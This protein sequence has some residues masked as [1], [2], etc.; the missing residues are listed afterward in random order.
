MNEMI[1]FRAVQGLGAGGLVIGAQAII[2][3]I[4]SPRERARYQGL[5]GAIF[6]LA[7]VVGPLVGGFFVDNLT[8]RWIFYINLPVGAVA[9]VIIG[10]VLTLP[11]PQ[12]RPRADFAG[13]A[14]LG[15]STVCIVLMFSWGGT[16][17]PWL[18]PQVIAVTAGAVIL[19]AAWAASASRAADPVLPLRLFRD[20][21]FVIACAISLILGIALFGAIAYLPAYLQIVNGASATSSGLLLLPIMAGVLVASIGSGRLIAR[22]GRYKVFP[23]AGTAVAG[24]G[25][26]LMS[27]MGVTTGRLA[28]A[29]Y[30]VVLGLG[31]GMFMQ[32]LVLVV[33]NSVARA[34]LGTATSSVNYFRQIGSTIGVALLGALLV[35]RLTTRLE[36][37]V[38]APSH[39]GSRLSSLTPQALAHLPSALHHAISVAFADAL[40]PLFAYL[41]PLFGVAFVLALL[42]EEKPLR[43]RAHLARNREGESQGLAAPGR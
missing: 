1:A 12:P 41:A 29:L 11:Q 24:A 22:T 7:S 8:W 38:P 33:Q 20:R 6:G 4:M 23:I 43:A 30:M 21:V 18:S 42:L 40:P 31:T 10:A 36:A 15:G 16:T 3:D 17:Y 9:L 5:I 34:D 19:A 13:M 27:T 35:H 32:V 26:L 25:L 39:V 14:L 37:Q 2:G 28:A